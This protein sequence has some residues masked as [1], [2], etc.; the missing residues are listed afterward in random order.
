MLPQRVRGNGY[1]GSASGLGVYCGSCVSS[2]DEELINKITD[3]FSQ[4]GAIAGKI[5][6]FNKNDMSLGFFNSIGILTVI[7]NGACKCVIG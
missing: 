5:V 4:I 7:S 2:D 3:Y 1:E 6:L